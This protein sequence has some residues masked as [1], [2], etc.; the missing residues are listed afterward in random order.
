[1]PKRAHW[2]RFFFMSSVAT[3]T[4]SSKI[5]S[6]A[7]LFEESLSR[8]EMKQG[9]VITAE[10]IRVDYNFVVVNAGLKSEAYIPLE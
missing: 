3:Q 9:E 10:V 2:N 4:S 1:M 7:A 5:E 8:Q 6:F